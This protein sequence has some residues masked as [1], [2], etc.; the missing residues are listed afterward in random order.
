MKTT[1][2]FFFSLSLAAL[3]F[4]CNDIDLVGEQPDDQQSQSLELVKGVTAQVADFKFD[5]SAF[6]RSSHTFS[7]STGYS[8]VWEQGD[9]LGIFPVESNQVEFPVKDGIGTNKAVFNGGAWALRAN[10]H[11]ASYYPFSSDNYHRKIT[12]LPVDYTDQTVDGNN[13]LAHLGK[14]DFLY[15]A[16]AETSDNGYVNLNLQ[17]L[18]CFVLFRLTLPEAGSYRYLNVTSEEVPLIHKATFDLS[19]STPVLTPTRSYTDYCINLKNVTANT[20]NEVVDITAMFAPLDLSGTTLKLSLMRNDGTMYSTTVAGK[21]ME[22]GKAYGFAPTVAFTEVVD[23]PTAKIKDGNTFNNVI[24][25]LAKGLNYNSSYNVLQSDD[26]NITRVNFEY[27]SSTNSGTIIS[28]TD[29]PYPIYVNYYNHIITVSTSAARISSTNMA[30]MFYKLHAL[31]SV[32]LS[33]FDT[34]NVTSMGAMLSGCSALKYINLSGL[35]TQNVTYMGNMFNKCSK[36]TSLD[37]SHFNT[38]SVTGMS[39]M[40]NECSRLKELNLSGFST[41]NVS[42]MTQMFCLCNAMCSLDLGS[43][44]VINSSTKKTNMCV[45]LASDPGVIE[46]SITCTSATKGALKN[47]TEFPYLN[48]FIWNIIE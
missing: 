9:T 43:K 24:K 38:Q 4:S 47:G 5:D 20:P 12:E 18:G 3:C 13:P 15:S 25:Q 14:Y 17:H 10:Y 44:F 29:S 23:V 19:A 42:D 8:F 39:N 35:N 21:N 27:N 33:G 45:G 1:S 6:T 48:K 7:S 36:L 32:D 41:N 31:E 22:A 30:S 16:P 46:C 26:D 37:L 2:K 11:Y 34:Q 40:F 28:T